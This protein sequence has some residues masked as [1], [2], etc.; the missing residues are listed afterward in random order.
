V[1]KSVI[2]ATPDDELEQ[3]IVDEIERRVGDDYDHSHEIVLSMPRGFRFIYAVWLLDAEVNNGGFNQFFWNSSGQFAPEALEG[4]R[5]I[6][7]TKHEELLKKA[8]QIHKDESAMIGKLKKKGTLEAFSESY[9][10]TKLNKLD[11]EYYKLPES[12]EKLNVKYIR[13]HV[14]LF[15]GK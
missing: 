13:D 7:A 12:L 10:Y 3:L 6:G 2:E 11:D 5:E 14:D 8:I 1:S 15:E 4:L 9:K